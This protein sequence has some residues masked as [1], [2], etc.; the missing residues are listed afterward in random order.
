MVRGWALTIR[1]DMPAVALVMLALYLVVQRPRFAFAGAGVLFYLAWAFKQSVI[2]ALVAVCLHLLLQKR[3]RDLSV[4]AAVFAALAAVT[5]LLGTP[6]YRYNILIAP[7]IVNE[8]SLAHALP[9]GIR[10]VLANA[11]WILAPA[12]LLTSGARRFDGAA[13]LLTL[14]LAVALAGGLAGMSKVGAYDNYL[15]EAFVAGSTLLQVTL[16]TAPGRLV[17]ALLCFALILPAIHLVTLPSGSGP[18]RTERSHMFGTVGIATDAQ[19]AEAVSLRD[20]MV[21]MKKPIFTTNEV[22][23]LPWFSTGN[24]APALVVD[25]NFHQAARSMEKY[26]GVEG[27]LQRGEIPTVMLESSDTDYLRSLNA[28][29]VKA[30]EAH[31]SGRYWSFYVFNPP[32]AT[33]Q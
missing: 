33:K 7:R 9:I 12:A 16:F 30:G 29:Y 18:G 5:I 6:E 17:N 15:L 23:C 21:A 2:L 24:Q 19:Y 14:V 3:W 32:P 4:L 22:F 26:G 25:R 8:F 11:Y 31:Y 10:S 27:L 13:R 1:P 28:N 20:R